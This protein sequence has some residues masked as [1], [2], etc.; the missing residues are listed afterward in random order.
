[1][2]GLLA[3]RALSDHFERVTVVERDVLKDGD[4]ARKGV[5]QAVHAHGLMA[6]GYR[7]MDAYFPGMMDELEALG[8]PRGDVVGDFLWFQYGR[9][10][11]RH[12]SGLRGITVSSPVSGGRGP[13]AGQGASQ[14]DLPRRCRGREPR[15]DAAT[16]RVTGFVVYQRDRDAPEI[17]EADLVVDATGR[18]SQ[19]AR[20]LEM[21]GFGRPEEI[22]VKVDVGYATRTFERRDGDF[23]NSIGGIIAGTAPASTRA[24]D[25]RRPQ[26]RHVR[27][28]ADRYRQLP[29]P[30]E[31]AATLRAHE[32][33]PAGYLVIGDAVCSF[34]P[35]Y[36]AGDVGRGHRGAGAR[37]ESLLR[38]RRPLPAV[39]CESQSHH[40]H[41]V[42]DRDGRR[43]ALPA[44]AG[45]APFRL[46]ARESIPRARA[47]GRVRRSSSV[48]KILRRAESARAATLADGSVGSVAC[49]GSTTP[50]GR[51]L[52]EGR[53]AARAGSCDEHNCQR[54]VV[55]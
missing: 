28:A 20:W 2:C 25:V 11:L 52:S 45:P 43:L 44:G 7:V 46:R 31:S 27:A 6:S 5:P 26:A 24:C 47:R 4:D 55:S 19:S 50:K 30:S 3:T 37:R 53:D 23:F 54:Q 42:D 14:R 39:L 51:E 34:N 12:R 40:R 38:T 13:P 16:S 17:L 8:A 18:G 32:A 49:A 15:L 9:W 1:M 33:F 29:L 48:P 36:R 21:C 10:K 41:P 35:I 22:T